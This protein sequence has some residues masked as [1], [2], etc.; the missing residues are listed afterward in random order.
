M[1]LSRAAIAAYIGLVFA[2]GAV[3]GAFGHRLYTASSVSAKAAKNPVEFRKRILANMERRLNLTPDQESKVNTILDET[4]ARFDAVNERTKP[5]LKAI[6]E[7]QQ[8]K[9]NAIL[10]PEQ[11]VEYAKM[12]K[13]R[14]ERLRQREAGK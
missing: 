14:E 4:R 8:N 5:E 2:S 11:Q 7:E 12:R 9:I 13:E 10:T 1:K 3:L 6:R